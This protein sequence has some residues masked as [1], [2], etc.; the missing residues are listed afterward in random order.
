MAVDEALLRS[1][2]VPTLRFYGWSEPSLSLGYFQTLE[3]RSRHAA[4]AQCP[5]VR[6]STGGGAIV[7]DQ[8]L[9]YSFTS[10]APFIARNGERWQAAELYG[11]FHESL[12][13][14]LAEF[15]LAARLA[16]SE[17]QAEAGAPER[18]T[19]PF[20]CFERREAGDVLLGTYKIAGSAQRRRRA[21]LL[22]H[23]SVLL[24]QSESAPELPGLFDLS[25]AKFEASEISQLWVRRIG[26]ILGLGFDG[27]AVGGLSD[28]EHRL[29]E[30]IVKEVFTHPSWTNRR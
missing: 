25:N 26:R 23:G 30:Q 28:D 22:Q 6:R 9:T 8:E 21:T 1:C 15:G 12:I 10:P 18:G 3:E 5:V 29:A 14:C 27:N 19:A 11:V 7:H 20:L 4:S 2:T 24:R 17:E 16:S 13:A